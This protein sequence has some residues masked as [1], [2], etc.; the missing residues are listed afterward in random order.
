MVNKEYGILEIYTEVIF[1]KHEYHWRLKSQDG[2]IIARSDIGYR[3][4]VECDKYIELVKHNIK[5]DNI[6]YYL[7]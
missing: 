3:D 5:T 2:D 7:P 1:N 6:F 4:K